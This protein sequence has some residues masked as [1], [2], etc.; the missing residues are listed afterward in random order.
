MQREG[1]GY[2]RTRGRGRGR[3]RGQE[4][5]ASNTSRRQTPVI[6]IDLESSS[7]EEKEKKNALMIK[8][9]K[10]MFEISLEAEKKDKYKSMYDKINQYVHALNLTPLSSKKVEG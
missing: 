9:R 2:L 10:P 5:G 4:V 6:N 7:E 3:G 8:K 1:G